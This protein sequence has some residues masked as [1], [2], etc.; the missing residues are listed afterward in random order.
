[1]IEVMRTLVSWL[2][3]LLDMFMTDG[4]YVGLAVVCL[5]VLALLIKA[6]RSLVS[7][8]S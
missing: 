3:N 2:T 8:K 6:I 4:G 1:M 7:R 5:P